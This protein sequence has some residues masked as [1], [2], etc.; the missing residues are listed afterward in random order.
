MTRTVDTYTATTASGTWSELLGLIVAADPATTLLS[1]GSLSDGGSSGSVTS[2]SVSRL[3]SDGSTEEPVEFAALD[4]LWAN[5]I[6]D[7]GMAPA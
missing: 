3:Q 7:G 2:S 6:F 1:D 5:W 4:T